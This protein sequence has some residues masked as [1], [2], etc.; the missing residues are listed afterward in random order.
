MRRAG[1]GGATG[2]TGSSTA[3]PSSAAPAAA[4]ST[5]AGA[6]AITVVRRQRLGPRLEEW[7]LRTPA[8][9]DPTRVRVLL[10][11]GYRSDATRRYPVLYLLHGADSDDTSWTRFGDAERI[12]A[13]APM[14]VV[15]PDGGA[16]GWYTD[17]YAGDRT[18]QPR[19]ETYHVGELVPWIDA[20]YRTVAAK[21]GRAIAGLS[22]GGYG[23]LSYAARHPDTF[24]AAAS[25]SGALEIGSED[26]WGVRSAQRGTVARAPADLDRVAAAVAR[27]RRDPHRQRAAGPARPP[28]ATQPGCP[29][30]SL[31][32]FLYPA[33]VRLHRRLQAL[34][35]RHVWDD[36]GP[37]THDWPYWR[38]DLRET[39]PGLERVLARS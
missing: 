26:A 19:W 37:G 22:M 29:A 11:A 17:W 16:Q 21:R 4:A 32:R 8:L 12:T 2:A 31:E 13:R 36:Y 27:A 10:P 20:T 30:C 6:R 15:M 9:S 33:N 24:A 14:I 23:A 7:T 34:G 3:T 1:G 39:L 5:P 28:A 38:R 35:I 18:A 25:F